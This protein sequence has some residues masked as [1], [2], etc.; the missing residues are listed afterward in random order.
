MRLHRFYVTEPIGSKKHI[1]ITSADTVSQIR[2]VFRLKPGDKV[3]VFD[4]SGFDFTCVIEKFAEKK[5]NNVQLQVMDMTRSRY[6][7]AHEVVLCAA[8]IKK[9]NFEWI[10]EKATELGVS[11]IIPILSERSEKKGL[12]L[13][14]IKKIA[15]EASE[16]SGRGIVPEISDVSS[17]GSVLSDSQS[18]FASKYV[19][20]TDGPALNGSEFKDVLKTGVPVMVF[21]GPEGGWT[22]K[23]IVEFHESGAKIICLGYQVLKAE[24]A[25]IAALSKF[26]L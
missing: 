25:V 12:N 21:I 17:L 11:K 24:T 8:L 14:R 20:H 7:G 1:E 2:R 5:E 26:L 22:E 3:I 23:E 18:L 13:E 9:D 4:G 16:Q 10:V 6:V 19:F 15:T